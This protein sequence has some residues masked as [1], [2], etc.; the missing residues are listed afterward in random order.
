MRKYGI[1]KTPCEV[2]QYLVSQEGQTVEYHYDKVVQFIEEV[3][4]YQLHQ[5]AEKILQEKDF[6]FLLK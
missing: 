2:K 4:N 1:T 5:L 6:Q 3:S